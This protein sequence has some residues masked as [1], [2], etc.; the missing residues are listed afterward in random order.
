MQ[1][2]TG[3][4]GY[5]INGV[6][7]AWY[8]DGLKGIDFDGNTACPNIS[9]ATVHL[10]G[11]LPLPVHGVASG[12]GKRRLDD[13]PPACADPGSWGIPAA[14]AA[15]FANQFLNDRAAVAHMIGKPYI[16]EETGMDVRLRPYLHGIVAVACCTK[17]TLCEC[18]RTPTSAS[19][20]WTSCWI[21][22][23]RRRT[24]TQ[25]P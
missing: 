15:A 14:D 17:L 13:A 21:C 19:P 23:Q 1:I 20:T 25:G 6:P 7:V 8:N 2:S 16:L 5:R 3:E 9:F 22:S 10:C 18:A 12:V 4:E 11:C 24:P